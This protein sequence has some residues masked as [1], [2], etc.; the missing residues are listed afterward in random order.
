[1]YKLEKCIKILHAILIYTHLIYS[2][3]YSASNDNIRMW[4]LMENETVLDKEHILSNKLGVPQVSFI[5]IP[6]HHGGMISEIY[7]DPS[8]RFMITSSGNRGWEEKTTNI[9]LFYTIKPIKN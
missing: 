1:L 7:I 5:I 8:C 9:C 6:G 3:E 4:N 2:N